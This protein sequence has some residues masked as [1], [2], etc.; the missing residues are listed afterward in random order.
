M[1]YLLNAIFS[2]LSCELK[3]KSWKTIRKESSQLRSRFYVKEFFLASVKGH[4][5]TLTRRNLFLPAEKGKRLP[6]RR[7]T[8]V[9]FVKWIKLNDNVLR[10]SL[11]ILQSCAG[12]NVFIISNH[13]NCL[14]AFRFACISR[15]YATRSI[16]RY[17]HRRFRPINAV[18][19]DARCK[20]ICKKCAIARYASSNFFF[21]G[22]ILRLGRGGV[23]IDDRSIFM[24]IDELDVSVRLRISNQ[25][26]RL[27]CRLHRWVG[28]V[29]FV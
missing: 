9:V 2:R 22:S 25:Y 21:I 13:F 8:S 12:A 16:I 20:K 11:F 7:C 29:N 23:L 26:Q 19:L 6:Q 1:K 17:F 5:W 27:H 18:L 10:L 15:N 4:N 28:F 3:L 24:G 14:L